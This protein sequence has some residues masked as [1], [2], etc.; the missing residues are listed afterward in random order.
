[1]VQSMK[2]DKALSRYGSQTE[3]AKALGV[4]RQV[5]HNW[6]KRGRVSLEGQL[7]LQ[8]LT[9]GKIRVERRARRQK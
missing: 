2:P 8:H 3:L 7:E 6:V 9:G 4:S 5:V 1:M